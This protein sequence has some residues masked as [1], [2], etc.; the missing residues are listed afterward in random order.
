MKFGQRG[1]EP[2]ESSLQTVD[3]FH[4]QVEE[5]FLHELLWINS[6][7]GAVLKGAALSLCF[8]ALLLPQLPQVL[9]NGD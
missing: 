6:C 1:N 7:P 3:C 4:H 5:R 2:L 8:L 9:G